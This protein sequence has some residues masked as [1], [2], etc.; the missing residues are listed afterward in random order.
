MSE[1]LSTTTGVWAGNPHYGSQTGDE[2]GYSIALNFESTRLAVGAP[3]YNSGTGYIYVADY[4]EDTNTWTQVGSNIVGPHT[5]SRFGHSIDMNWTGDRI[6]VGANTASNVYIYDYSSGW[7][8]N[9]VIDTSIASFGHCV[10]LAGDASNR[11]CVGAPDVNTIYVYEERGGTWNL[12]Y[13]N[14][15]TDFENV[16]ALSYGTPYEYNTIN[17]INVNSQYTQYG[18]SVSMSAFGEHVLVGAP[19]SRLKQIDTTNSDA[20]QTYLSNTY[21]QDPPPNLTN[22]NGNYQ[23][24]H[25]RV[26]RCPEN[27]D[28][29]SGVTQVG[30]LLRGDPNGV[31]LSGWFPDF[32]SMPGFGF[33][34]HISYDGNIIT[35]V[36]VEQGEVTLLNQFTH[37]TGRTNYFVYNELEGVWEIKEYLYGVQNSRSGWGGGLSY[38]G[39]RVAKVALNQGQ[40]STMYDWNG[41]SFYE[42]ELPIDNISSSYGYQQS[43]LIG[44]D[45]AMVNG[46][47]VAVSAPYFN[48][49]TG[50]VHVFK[51]DLT[52]IFNGNSLFSGYIKAETVYIGTNDTGINDKTKRLLFGGTNGDDQYECSTVENRVYNDKSSELLM[53]KLPGNDGPRLYPDRVRLKAPGIL[54]DCPRGDLLKNQSRYTESPVFVINGYQCTG[55]GHYSVMGPTAQ[56]DII[57]DTRTSSKFTVSSDRKM[58]WR[59]I[60][61][62]GNDP[63]TEK[64]GCYLFYNTRDS[65]LITNGTL[66]NYSFHYDRGLKSKGNPTNVTHDTNVKALSFSGASS[67]VTTTE[68][69]YYNEFRNGT[70]EDLLE[71]NSLWVRF[72]NISTSYE[73][74]LDLGGYTLLSFKEDTVRI[75]L[76][77]GSDVFTSSQTFLNNVWYHVFLDINRQDSN[78]GQ[79]YLFVLYIN[80]INVLSGQST[81]NFVL[82]AL[83]NRIIF[84]G[85]LN[86]YIGTPLFSIDETSQSSTELY[87]YGP[88]DEVLA[89]GGGAT[90]A[91]KLGVGVTNPRNT[92]TVDSFDPV[93]KLSVDAGDTS[94]NYILNSPKPG[95]IIGGAVHFINGTKRSA[96]G[97]SSTY[98]I[99]NE[100]GPLRLG[101]S[102]YDTSILSSGVITQTGGGDA[103]KIRF[104]PNSTWSEYLNIGSGIPSIEAQVISTNGNLHLDP[105]Y[106]FNMYLCYFNGGSVLYSSSATSVHSSDDRLKTEEKNIENAMETLNKL[107]PQTYMKSRNFENMDDVGF[108]AGLIAQEV[109]YQCPEL[110]HLVHVPK[111][112][113]PDENIIIP[114][115]PQI[116]PDYS[117]WGEMEAGISYTGIIPYIIKANQELHEKILQLTERI[118][119]LESTSSQHP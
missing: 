101:S 16:I 42:A 26:F 67:F 75:T 30:Q 116:D 77:G 118:Q 22:D 27:G 88:P 23:S 72:N 56:M 104:G 99:R 60:R 107:K 110:R 74:V 85:G 36:S 89:V 45:Y 3:G 65:N 62:P 81:N 63:L 117:S 10:S 108:E 102:S 48:S 41:N 49:K 57:G 87:N 32:N 96:D 31:T 34:T 50:S 79:K 98:T 46:K 78:N 114:D 28:W 115:D 91:G 97:G 69:E 14:V 44:F 6:I 24:G 38:D 40:F 95:E 54:F 76:D 112:A 70:N 33:N 90:I 9:H 93:L 12:D 39:S 113:N 58:N 71:K 111:D 43:T 18:Y 35:V 83:S 80:N 66:Q 47:Y 19:G 106:G 29:T 4:D 109:Y 119:V 15:G 17:Y 51:Y 5:T 2:F 13:S 61:G 103:T 55:V 100:S 84:G 82:G 20:T 59:G 53:A 64:T 37:T 8:L 94:Y 11:L 68:Y 86:G 21:T 7:S 105:K 92:L 1:V 52:S 25:A 73:Q